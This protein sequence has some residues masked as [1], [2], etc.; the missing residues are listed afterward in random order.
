MQSEQA[1]KSDASEEILDT[2][3][4]R[5]A[6]CIEAE[7]LPHAR[8]L[9]L[10]DQKFL[11]GE[12]WPEDV[13]QARTIDKRPCLVVNRMPQFVRQVTN[14]QRQNRPSIKVSPVDDKADVDTAKVLQGH[15]RHIEYQSNA[16]VAYDT[17]FE[18]AVG[19]GFGFFRIISEY[20]DPYTFDQE[21]RIK[22]IPNQF[23]VHLDPASVEP[24]G[25][26]ANFAFIESDL[27][28]EEYKALW[29]DSEMASHESW[30]TIGNDQPGWATGSRCRVVEYFF[31]DMEQVALVQMSN[32]WV[33]PKDQLPGVLPEGITILQ[34]R[35]ARIPVVKWVKM[36]AVEILE[37]T[38]I[39]IPW[40]PVIPV[41]GDRRFIDG[42]V[43]CEGIIRHAKDS[44]RML[45]YFISCETEAIALAPRAPFIVAEGQIEEQYANEWASS[46]SRNIAYLTYQNIPGA[47]P[48]S[49]NFGEPNVQA[50]TQARIQAG[51][52]IKST[53]GI[54]DASLG[55]RSNEQS[56]IAIQRRNMQAQ[57]S[58]FHFVD[59]LSRSIRHAGRILVA[60]IPKVYDT[61]RTI[62]VLG[63]DGQEEIVKINAVF[64]E[65]GE[66]K[67]YDLG[68]GKYDVT[69]ST[70]PSFQTKRQ[71]AQ[72]MLMEFMKVIPQHA[73][74]IADLVADN[75]DWN[76]KDA[77]KERLR[78]L[79][80]PGLAEDKEQ[81]PIPPEVQAQMQQMAQ[82]NEQLTQALDQK[83][84]Q[85]EQKTLELESK[86]RIEMQK[87]QVQLEI[88]RAKLD[89]KDSLRMFDAELAQIENRMN[90]LRQN[91]PI[92][93]E[94]PASGGMPAAMPI[95]EQQ[96]L[97]APTP[98]GGF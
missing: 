12:Q 14:D 26:D 84:Q 8:P 53:T 52:D 22:A 10:E 96:P 42:E 49:R 43:I 63:E 79:L 34:E 56:G 40:I 86:E 78:K 65:H 25:S 50:I 44:Q 75:S 71:E 19:P 30:E 97:G 76:G 4:A 73:P 37:E 9:A 17:A 98:D 28:K 87:L 33:G 81:K 29:P 72:A 68:A 91:V 55:A 5:F 31:K 69:V 95:Q 35:V 89:A 66:A 2:G 24:D 39:P 82:M 93:M 70:G 90:L 46:S 6:Q 27:S 85:I 80:P 54:Y 92:E 67:K 21:L 60:W 61:E 11:A 7:S 38:V 94:Q 57:T 41:Y 77:L 58:N 83:T 62:R 23:S 16:D 48:P 88:E 64:Q 36:N 45:N 47:P 74:M 15:I 20:C 3:K 18:G 13:K 51:D 59:N 1:E 32:G